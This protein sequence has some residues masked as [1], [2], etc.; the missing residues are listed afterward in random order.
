ME[1][2][3]RGLEIAQIGAAV[4]EGTRM[5]KAGDKVYIDGTNEEGTVKEVHPHEAVVRVE[6]PGGHEE[7]KYSH[8]R[9]RL[10]PTMQEASHFI[11][12]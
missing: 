10:D 2:E 8:E 9:L 4:T 12:H 6:I 11:D 5:L 3:G 1:V 7:R